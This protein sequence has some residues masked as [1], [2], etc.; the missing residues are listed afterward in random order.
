MFEPTHIIMDIKGTTQADVL[1]E[2]ATKAYELGVVND[3]NQLVADYLE[4]EAE[5]TT[6]FGNGVAIPHSKSSNNKQATILFARADHGVEWQALDDA[7]VDTWLSLIVP[8]TEAGL[9]LQLLA[10]L[11]RQLVHP[12]FIE[13]LKHGTEAE[14]TTLLNDIVG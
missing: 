3:A 4:R 12:E 11:S 1:A 14:I 5:S 13:T 10:K 6:G 8:D 2:L 7:P 9:H